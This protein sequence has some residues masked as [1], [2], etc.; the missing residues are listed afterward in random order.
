M[1]GSV[2]VA[3]VTSALDIGYWI[4]DIG[5]WINGTPMKNE[6]KT[7][8]QLM[9]ELAEMRQRLAE[10]EASGARPAPSGALLDQADDAVRESVARYRSMFDGVPVGLYQTSS[11]GQIL[12]ANPALVKMLFYPDRET[13]L[14]AGAAD[15][16]VDPQ[17]RERWQALMEREGVVPDFEMQMR[18]F[19]D[20]VIWVKDSARVVFDANGSVLYYEGA[21]EDIT[22]RKGAEEALKQTMA[23]LARSNAELEQFAYVASH[24][25]QEPLRM[26]ASYMQLLQRRYQGKLDA[27]A[28]EF[29]AYAVDGAKR[30][31]ALINDLLAYSRVS[32]RGKPFEPI[33][34]EVVLDEALAN[35]QMA[36]EESDAVIIRDP[37]PTVMADGTQLMQLFQNLIGNGIKFQN[38]RAPHVH[39]STERQA[40]EWVFSVC[41]NG[42]GI[43]PRYH[44]RVFAV[45]RRLHTREEYPGTGIG[46][47]ICK[48]IVE[49]HGGRIWVESQSGE[50][51]TFHFAI[52]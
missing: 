27:D 28:D 13:F 45:F 39:V 46:L 32:S 19:D 41:D 2:A 9:Q 37:L 43:D 1:V 11:E 3:H 18:R 35:L 29:I 5:D 49:R 30:M 17:S 12:D 24:D 34:C 7:R 42:I 21:L 8:A 23:E 36:I 31:Q 38:G 6:H 33:D 47:A 40:G 4:L 14:K 25:L 51:S 52:P 48:R 10:L 20:S 15:V 50:G 44:E 16:Y 22:E 26:V